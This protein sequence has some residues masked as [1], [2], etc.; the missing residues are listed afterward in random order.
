[1]KKYYGYSQETMD[2]ALSGTTPTSPE[3]IRATIG[4]FADAGIDELV[5]TA[6]TT[7][8][9]PQLDHLADVIG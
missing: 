1:M 4:R 2:R 6:T 3:A 9:L 5:F 7:D 8:P